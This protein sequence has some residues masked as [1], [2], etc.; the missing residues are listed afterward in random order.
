MNFIKMLFNIL[1]IKP[2]FGDFV[3]GYRVS[4]LFD[5][6]LSIV[7]N[8]LWVHIWCQFDILK[9]CTALAGWIEVW[10]FAWQNEQ[11]NVRQ[12]AVHV[13]QYTELRST[14]SQKKNHMAAPSRVLNDKLDKFDPLVSAEMI[15]LGVR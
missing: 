5:A 12:E 4:M 13:R 1:K 11:H 7:R 3:I 14:E 15:F 10:R 2:I 6:D 9:Y 8:R